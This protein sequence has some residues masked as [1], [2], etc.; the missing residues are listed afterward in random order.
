MHYEY[1]Q[2]TDY[3]QYNNPKVNTLLS[4]ANS[5]YDI[6]KR[7]ALLQQAEEIIYNQVPALYLDQPYSFVAMSAP[8]QGYI[9]YPDDIM[10]VAF[11][12]WG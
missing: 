4:E 3:Y 8:I 6:A 11:L 7:K 12:R 10:H 5:T 9:H 2:S 1:G